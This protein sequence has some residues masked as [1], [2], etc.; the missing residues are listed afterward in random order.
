MKKEINQLFR[1]SLAVINKK[2]KFFKF[3]GKILGHFSPNIKGNFYIRWGRGIHIA[4]LLISLFIG[5]ESCACQ[6]AHVEVREQL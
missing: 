2:K 1:S 3:L 6:G 5:R 4:Y